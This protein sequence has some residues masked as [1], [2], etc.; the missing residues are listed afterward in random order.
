MTS[1]RNCQRGHH[2]E[3]VLFIIISN[4]LFLSGLWT[5][6]P[7]LQERLGMIIN[8]NIPLWLVTTWRIRKTFAQDVTNHN[9]N[10]NKVISYEWIIRW[11]ILNE[12][13]IG[14]LWCTHILSH[15]SSPY[16]SMTVQNESGKMNA[17]TGVDWHSY[18]C[19]KVLHGCCWRTCR[20]HL[21]P[22]C[23]S[24]T[25]G[26]RMNQLMTVPMSD[27][28]LAESFMNVTHRWVIHSFQL[29]R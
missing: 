4:S 16:E 26:S 22:N 29:E 1:W 11:A 28:H 6:V 8:N 18:D 13:R 2:H 21:V 10:N 9:A 24:V 3:G 5:C 7:I 15:H 14:N 25:T 12:M 17:V 27:D 19:L 20:W 23:K